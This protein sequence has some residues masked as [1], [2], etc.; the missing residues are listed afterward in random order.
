MN[1]FKAQRLKLK[2]KAFEPKMRFQALSQIYA[3]VKKL[4]AEMKAKTNKGKNIY[5]S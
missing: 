4:K 2:L 3:L 5:L 1:S